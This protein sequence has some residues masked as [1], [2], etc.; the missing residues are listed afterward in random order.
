MKR[1]FILF[2]VLLSS[3]S[4]FAQHRSEQE[5]IQVAQEFFTSRPAVQPARLVT[6]P[7]RQVKEKVDQHMAR[8]KKAPAKNSACYIIND[9][10]NNRFVIVSA[11][12]R[13]YNILG[14]SDNGFFDVE[15][16]PQALSELIG[17]Y[18]NQYDFLLQNGDHVLMKTNAQSVVPIAPM[19]STK[20]DQESPYNDECPYDKDFAQLGVNLRSATGCAATA[21]AQIMNYHKYPQQGEGIITYTESGANQE[22]NLSTVTFDWDNMANEYNS[23]SDEVQKHAVAQLMHVCGLSI[24]MDYTAFNSSAAT[25]DVAY[26]LSHYFNYN[27]NIKYY[28]RNYF[29]YAEWNSIILND[30]RHGLPVFYGGQTKTYDKEGNVQKDDDGN[31]ITGGHGFVIDGCDETLLYHMNFG[32]SG[33]YDGYYSLD[34]ITLKDNVNYE[35]SQEMVCNI[36]PDVMGSKEDIFINDIFAL[37]ETSQSWVPSTEFKKKTNESIRIAY[38]PG[39]ICAN[40]NTYNQPFVGEYGIGLF[41]LNYNYITSLKRNNVSFSD[42]FY[43]G[44]QFA[45]YQYEQVYFWSSNFKNGNQY[46]IAPYAKSNDSD[47]PSIMRTKTFYSYLASVKNDTISIILYSEPASITGEDLQIA[48]SGSAKLQ[49]D[50]DNI[51][52]H[53]RG[54]Q[55]DL[56]LPQGLAIEKESDGA[57]A[58][59]LSNRCTGENIEFYVMSTED[60]VYRFSVLN[61]EVSAGQG[62]L[63][64]IAVTSSNLLEGEHIANVSNAYMVKPNGKFESLGNCNIKVMVSNS[65][66]FLGD[67]NGDGNVDISD[68]TTDVDYIMGNSPSN[69]VFENADVDEDSEIDVADITLTV[70]IILGPN[71]AM[72]IA[73]LP[74]YRELALDNNGMGEY[75]V[76][77][78]GADSYVASQFDIVTTSSSNIESISLKETLSDSHILSYNKIG[79]NRYRVVVYSLN[80]KPYDRNNGN[81]FT[82]KTSNGDPIEIENMV[83]V[84]KDNEKRRMELTNEVTKIGSVKADDDFTIYSVN[85]QIVRKG[86]KS[87]EN[88]PKGVYIINGVKHVVK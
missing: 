17:E 22:L 52:T 87:T 43:A 69:F 5:A 70:N 23:N 67:S 32:Y 54:F 47:E 41:D 26:A 78:N 56:K 64:E 33:E 77:L 16:M 84:T 61:T 60:N 13:M 86:A 4:M 62:A 11:D 25:I 42:G 68:V 88:L 37:Y 20:W 48:S 1:I 15:K 79:D 63:M 46:I 81:L 14:Y 74:V 50:L 34:A 21:M 73:N 12:E 38:K 58:A 2:C 80:N 3:I 6:V 71:T 18:G 19:L 30:L 49:I 24:R 65:D 29:T 31:Y 66:K 85:G 40:T 57:F 82:I 7:Q 75:S 8:A 39:S 28:L 51:N 27:P 35:L 55:F 10:V 72:N 83:F 53:Y 59:Q 9:E 45:N 44:S 36:S 76:K